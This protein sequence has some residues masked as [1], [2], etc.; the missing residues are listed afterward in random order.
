[1]ATLDALKM[2][3]ESDWPSIVIHCDFHPGN[4]KIS[5]EEIVGLFDFDWSKIDLRCFDVALA[6]WY[7]FTSWRGELDGA[8]RL[9]EFRTF[10]NTYQETFQ[11]QAV[12]KPDVSAT[13]PEFHPMV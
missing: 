3:D 1:M 5:A 12:L 2:V 8:L 9:A 6:G 7:F 10:L 4:L 11:D 13:F